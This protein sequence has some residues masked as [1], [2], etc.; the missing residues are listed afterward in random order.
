MKKLISATTLRQMA[1]TGKRVVIPPQSVLTPSAQDL[2]KELGIQIVRGNSKELQGESSR[3]DITSNSDAKPADTAGALETEVRK[4]LS[5]LLKPACTNPKVTQVKGASVV[6]QPFD[7]APPGQNIKLIDVIT[8]REANLAAGFMAF[9][10]SELPWNLTY[11]EVDY[12]VE[13]TFTVET[14]GKVYTCVA[15]DVL[16]IPKDTR[17]VF[18]SPNQAKVFYVTYPA[19][20]SDL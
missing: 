10:C 8:A 16:Y 20:W 9:D 19:N 2:A 13:G 1:E 18:G 17:V 5:E 12:V 11:D 4:V 6:L 14:G 7:Q 15:G 3:Q